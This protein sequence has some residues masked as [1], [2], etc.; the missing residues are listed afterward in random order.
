MPKWENTPAFIG[1]VPGAIPTVMPWLPASLAMVATVLVND[2]QI[3]DARSSVLPSWNTP[4]ATN[5]WVAPTEIEALAGA[6]VM[7]C[8]PGGVNILGW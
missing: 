8:S 4:V 5:L 6:I 1:D 2:D 7:D 3:T